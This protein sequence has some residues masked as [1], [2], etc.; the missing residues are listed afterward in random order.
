MFDKIDINGSKKEMLLIVHY[1]M[2]IGNETHRALFYN[3]DSVFQRQ[4]SKNSQKES[5][6]RFKLIFTL[7]L[8][9]KVESVLPL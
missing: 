6:L 2:G 7:K 9:A 5:A 4:N 1:C 8:N 3:T